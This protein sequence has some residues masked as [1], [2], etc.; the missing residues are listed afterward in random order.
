MLID[1]EPESGVVRVDHDGLQAL[2]S[3]S[4]GADV[5]EAAAVLE[6]DG[7]ADAMITVTDPEVTVELVVAGTSTRLSHRIWVDPVRAVVLPEVRPGVAQLMVVPPGHLAAA[8]A[9]L[10]RLRP[11]RTGERGVRPF[12]ADRLEDLVAPDTAL[13]SEAL[14]LAGAGFAW[15]LLVGWAGADRRVTA[16]DGPGGPFLADPDHGVLRPTTNTILYR[17]FATVLPPPAS[18]ARA[19]DS[20]AF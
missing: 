1:R 16:V 14:A 4:R 10:T 18:S 7:V 6:T 20:E 5:P 2:V 17:L 11:R 3:A 15:Q 12:P 13:R 8:L 19:S 9:R